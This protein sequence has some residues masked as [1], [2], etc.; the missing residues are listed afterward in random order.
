MRGPPVSL[1]APSPHI[2]ACNPLKLRPSLA[3]ETLD[4]TLQNKSPD[5][6]LVRDAPSGVTLRVH[7]GPRL[8]RLPWNGYGGK[9]GQ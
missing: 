7:P 5:L 8:Q 1:A 9:D 3:D 6:N 2:A 4:D